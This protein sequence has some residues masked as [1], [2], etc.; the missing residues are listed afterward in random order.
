MS[1]D[2]ATFPSV[3]GSAV[4][5]LEW[6][7]DLLVIGVFEDSF[8]EKGEPCGLHQTAPRHV[9][10]P[11]LA[12]ARRHRATHALPICRRQA[13]DQERRASRLGPPAGR[14]AVRHCLHLRLCRQEGAQWRPLAGAPPLRARAPGRPP[15]AASASPTCFVGIHASGAR[16]QG[17]QVCGSQRL[18]LSRQGR[19]LRRI[20]GPGRGPRG[21]RQGQQGDHR[22]GG[23]P[24]ACRQR[25]LAG[26]PAA[27]CARLAGVFVP[28]L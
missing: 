4:A 21:R 28:S 12:S 7:G 23:H 10:A 16:Q 18:G 6:Q 3:S 19:R 25:R 8:E 2:P 15:T 9:E 26:A 22:R 20:P 14:R 1:L 5:Q 13:H 11:R 24:G 27:P 17:G